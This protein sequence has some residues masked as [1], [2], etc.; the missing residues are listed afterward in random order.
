MNE[1]CKFKP[2][3]RSTS[4]KFKDRYNCWG[5]SKLK[6]N[7]LWEKWS[8][9]NSKPINI[10]TISRLKSEIYSINDHNSKQLGKKMP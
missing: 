4:K 9:I 7:D 8:D 6:N 2:F 1:I 10:L 5:K 3:R